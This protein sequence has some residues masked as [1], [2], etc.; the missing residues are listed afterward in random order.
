MKLK[1]P[2][3]MRLEAR[4]TRKLIRSVVDKEYLH[5]YT[6]GCRGVSVDW[7]KDLNNTRCG[8]DR[9]NWIDWTA[10]DVEICVCGYPGKNPENFHRY[11]RGTVSKMETEGY[12]IARVGTYV[13]R[14]WNGTRNISINIVD[15]NVKGLETTLSFVQCPSR[16]TVICAPSANVYDFKSGRKVVL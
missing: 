13:R 11:V 10:N 5:S 2:T 16:S 14:V 1:S 9:L 7:W 15:V 8:R 12:E 3:W 6:V 4:N